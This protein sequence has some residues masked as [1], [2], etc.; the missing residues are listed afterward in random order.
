MENL[1]AKLNRQLV[2]ETDQ[3]KNFLVHDTF[4]LVTR[5]K[6]SKYLKMK[7]EKGCTHGS[8]SHVN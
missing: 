6:A 8:E 7:L 4:H 5:F 1:E 3:L 2:S